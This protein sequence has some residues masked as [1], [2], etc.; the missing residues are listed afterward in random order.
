MV[1]ALIFL[2]RNGLMKTLANELRTGIEKHYN[3]TDK[4]TFA[5]PSVASIWDNIQNDVR[6]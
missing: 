1:A 2:F 3:A 5:V 4:G 6:V